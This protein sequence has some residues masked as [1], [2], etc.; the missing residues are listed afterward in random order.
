[1]Q[2]NRTTMSHAYTCLHFGVIFL[3]LFRRF[4]LVSAAADLLVGVCLFAAFLRLY[5]GMH[6][7][8]FFQRVA[9]QQHV[10]FVVYR[11]YADSRVLCRVKCMES[12]RTADS[13]YTFSRLKQHNDSHFIYRMERE[14]EKKRI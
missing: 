9:V 11:F 5:C 6:A 14:R 12:V 1:M 8:R 7:T 3:P 2:P 10:Y 13:E 4:P